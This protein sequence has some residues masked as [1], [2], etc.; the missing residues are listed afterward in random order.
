MPSSEKVVL[1]GMISPYKG[2]QSKDGSPSLIL[3][4]NN[5]EDYLLFEDNK[6]KALRELVYERVLI[7]G[8]IDDSADRPTIKVESY[9]RLEIE[10]DDEWRESEYMDY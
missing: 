3:M 10:P 5:G 6:A 9:Q 2:W 4:G 1:A 8:E 7:K